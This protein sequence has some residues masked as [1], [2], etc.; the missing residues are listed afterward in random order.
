M[1]AA[2]L[3]QGISCPS[4]LSWIGSLTFTFIAILGVPNARLIQQFG[5]RRTAFYGFTILALSE[6]I[7]GSFMHKV[8]GFFVTA[9]VL[10]GIGTRY[11][12]S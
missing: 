2:L 1:Q 11:D 7:S 8:G 10:S 12:D 9:G 3:A 5:P 4:T 6:I